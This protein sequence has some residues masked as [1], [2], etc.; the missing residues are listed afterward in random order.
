MHFA[1]LDAQHT[2]E[3]VMDEVSFII[4]Y[5]QKGDIIF[6][7][8]V[9]PDLFPGVVAAVNE[10]GNRYNYKIKHMIASEQRGYAIA[11]RSKT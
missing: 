3:A 4:D 5:Q 11:T 6:F 1:F 7:D 2:Y 10:I 9:T 8:D